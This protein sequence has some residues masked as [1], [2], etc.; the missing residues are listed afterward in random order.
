MQAV[1][2]LTHQPPLPGRAAAALAAPAAALATALAAATLARGQQFMVH[3]R[4]S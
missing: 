4:R 1:G 2:A 3:A